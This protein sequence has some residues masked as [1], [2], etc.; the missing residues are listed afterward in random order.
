MRVPLALFLAKAPQAMSPPAMSAKRSQPIEW[1]VMT[2][3]FD[4]AK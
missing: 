4:A 1:A 2:V 3:Y